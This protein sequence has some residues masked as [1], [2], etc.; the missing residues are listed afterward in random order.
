LAAGL[1]GAG[2]FF[3]ATDFFFAGTGLLFAAGFLTGLTGDFFFF[4]A[5][6]A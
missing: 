6:M 4:A 2:F 1:A 5:A 3:T